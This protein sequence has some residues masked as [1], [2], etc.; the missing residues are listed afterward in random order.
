MIHDQRVATRRARLSDV[1]DACTGGH[2]FSWL[3][4][5]WR[6]SKEAAYQWCARSTDVDTM[7]TLGDNGRASV[8]MPRE[9]DFARRLELIALC[10]ENG[11]TYEAIAAALGVTTTTVFEFVKRHAPFGMDEAVNDLREDEAA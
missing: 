9:Y 1:R 6:V 3:G 10:R 11:W 2:G 8:G 7:A 4:R 5:R